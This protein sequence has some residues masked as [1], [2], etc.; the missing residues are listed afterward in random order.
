MHFRSRF[1][2]VLFIIFNCGFL[3]AQNDSTSIE[4]EILSLEELM[5]MAVTGVSRYSQNINDAP[6]TVVL[7]TDVMIKNRGYEDLADLLKDMPGTDL[8]DNAGRYGQFPTIRGIDGNDRFLV[9]IDGHKLNPAGG[10]FL[11][12]GHS[13]S[14]NMAKRVEIIYG[15]ASAV[16]GADAFAGIINII[17]KESGDN[18]DITLRGSLGKFKNGIASLDFA[19]PI[20]GI[21]EASVSAYF[22]LYRSEGADFSELSSDYSII[23]SY[24]DP[25]KPEFRQMFKDHTLFVNGTYKQLRLSFYQQRFDEGNARGM[26]PNNYYYNEQNHWALTSS[27]LWGTYKQPV[28]N[29]GELN[30]DISYTIHTQDNTTRFDK[31]VKPGIPDGVYYQYLT[32][33]D[34]TIKGSITY[35]DGFYENLKFISGIEAER[36]SSIPPYA[37]DEIIGSSVK[38]EGAAADKIDALKIVENRVG[39]FGQLTYNP[40]NPLSLFLGARYDYSEQ[41]DNS[42]NPR[43]GA[44]YKITESTTIKALYGTAFQA[45]SLFYRYEQFGTPSLAMLSGSEANHTLK[46]Q[47][48]QSYEFSVAQRLSQKMNLSVSYYYN[49]LTD[50]INRAPYPA[51]SVFNKYFNKYTKAIYNKNVGSQQVQGIDV[52]FLTSLSEDLEGYIYYSYADAKY[53]TTDKKD[54]PR[55]SDHKVWTGVTYKGIEHLVASVNLKWVSDINVSQTNSVYKNGAKQPGYLVMNLSASLIDL[56][57]GARIFTRVENVLNSSINHAGLLDQSGL[58]T[59]VIP[60]P[61]L[62]GRLGFEVSF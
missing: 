35:N 60:Q 38:Y 16:Y 45:P 42:L 46:N 12:I 62:S 24:K 28:G 56:F 52:H 36:T 48:L 23:D 18:T 15:P 50:L 21:D 26:N 47:K 8:T 3:F 54:L 17:T 44:V 2:A 31:L 32:G 37:N 34:R 10:M 58:Y 30:V 61:K 11:S 39:V 4:I 40:W 51:D 5:K 53:G 1:A 7:I 14:L 41:Y 20:K 6:A 19:S 9:L 25:V 33:D 49:D 27:I 13:I 55:V 59:A 57:P 22:Q 43:M 29:T